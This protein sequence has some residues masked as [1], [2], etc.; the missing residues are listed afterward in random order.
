MLVQQVT[1]L[2]ERNAE[3]RVLL[4]QPGHGGLHDQPSAAEQVE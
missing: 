3:R 1:A 4:L 2:M